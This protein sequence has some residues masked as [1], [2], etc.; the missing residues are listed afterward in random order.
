[1]ESTTDAFSFFRGYIECSHEPMSLPAVAGRRLDVGDGI[2]L[3]PPSE[4]G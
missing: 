3:F 2:T 4:G 1:M